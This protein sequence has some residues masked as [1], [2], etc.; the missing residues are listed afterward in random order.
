MF[1]KFTLNKAVMLA[2]AILLFGGSFVSAKDNKVDFIENKGQWEGHKIRYKA[3]IPGG[4]FYLTDKGFVYNFV[5]T[6]DWNAYSESLEH[7][8]KA[9]P[10]HF[11][12]Y[13]VNFVGANPTTDITST[14]FEKRS[15]YNN[16]FIG[17]D[18]SK[19][20][21]HVGLYGKVKLGN[22]YNGI[23]VYVYNNTGGENT[24]SLKYDFVVGAGVN[25]NQI[26]LSFDG[27]SPQIG[28]D[29]SLIIQTTVNKIVEQAP[30]CYQEINGQKVT[31]PSKYLL[32]NGTLTFAFPNGYNQNYPLVIDPNLVFATYSG[33][34]S[35][36]VYAYSTT[37]DDAGNLYAGGDVWDVGWPVTTGAFQTTFAG[38][39]HDIGINKYST[40]GTTLIYS[41]YYGGSGTEYPNAMRVNAQ[42]ELVLAGSTV[43]SDLPMGSNA[44][45]SSNGGGTDYFIAHF[46]QD[47]SS[48]I[49]ATY[50]GGSG[51]PSA[52]SIDANPSVMTG[53]A[54][55]HGQISPIDF[56]F[57]ANG[58]IWVVGNANSSTFPTTSNAQQAT[59]AGG[60]DGILAELSSDCSQLIYSSFLGGTGTDLAT[61]ILINHT[62]D[63]VVCGTTS[64]TNFPTTSGSYHS[65]AP[66]GSY[67][68]FVSII[69]PSNG[70]ISHSTYVG[71][72]KTDEAMFLQEDCA[73]NIYVLGST[74]GDYPISPGAWVT[75]SDGDVFVDKLNPDLSGSIISTR[76]G[77]PQSG[78]GAYYP[79][80]FLVDICGRTYLAGY[81]ES[82]GSANLPVT[83][84]AF[85]GPSTP[86]VNF[87]FCALEPSFSDVQYATF[88][89]VPGDHNHVGINRMDP[90][91]NV[92]Q[93]VCSNYPPNPFTAPNVWS[94]SKQT[95]GQDVLSFKFSFDI[96]TVNLSEVTGGGGNEAVPHAVRGCKS[97]Y[98]DFVRN[99]P[100]TIPLTIH[101][102]LSGT[103]NINS[104]YQV[105]SADSITIPAYDTIARLE[106]K[107]LI[108]PG[109]PTGPKNVHIDV[110]SPCGCDGGSNNI[111]ASGDIQIL[112]S[113]Y[114]DIPQPTQV[115]CA[116]S[117]VTVTAQIDTNLNFAWAPEN[118]IPD[119]R[120]LGLTI[121][122]VPVHPT[123]YTIT[124]T[125]PGAPATCPPHTLH[126][127][128]NVE[129]YPQV[130]M[131]AK[132]TIV[133]INPGDS[134][135]L[136][137]FAT[138]EGVNYSYQWS[139]AT[140]LRDAVSR[141][142][143][144]AGPVGD[145]H[146]TLTV[147]SPLAHCTGQNDMIIHVVP[148]FHFSSVTPADTI[149]NYG[150]AVKLNAEGNAVAWVWLP[151]SYLD[152]ANLQ[153]PT[154]KPEQS[155]QYQVVGL[156]EYGCRDT[157]KVNIQVKY[158][159][160]FFIPSAFSPN[161]DGNN[162]I[163]KIENLR[164]EKL[165]TF[166]V[167]NRLGQLVFST[168]NKING[169]DGTF[170]G[171][172]APADT[173]FYLIEVVL[174]DGEHQTFKGNIT[175]IR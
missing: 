9:Q 1:C 122:P 171:K 170:N 129:Q 51:T 20:A 26:K 44:Y 145:Y 33:A 127:F 149:V 130:T 93:S 96:A 161:G 173:Y 166:K 158:V 136:N 21:G 75:S 77:T 11:H 52:I 10:I 126:Y 81:N 65:T 150:D 100:D 147:S 58:N 4:A 87:W 116:N 45:Q 113:L 172:A 84:N 97:A 167:F 92:Y 125:Q 67:D 42:D 22:I 163:F 135:Q 94:P 61:G 78:Y 160:N 153:S 112:D 164:F 66:G 3:D 134:V 108:V 17:K 69:D 13:K 86:P 28:A 90:Q 175:L 98:F 50:L 133:C 115:V 155:I 114:V 64:S 124:V 83:S 104:D 41:T 30:Y 76:L 102:Q 57:D 143:M 79:T 19:W 156:D 23:D 123:D 121:H 80:S 103:A 25:V 72:D 62:G 71:T 24:S 165:L 14:G 146:Y 59:I 141:V 63:I 137:A 36:N 117:P 101:Y 16:Y 152:D 162:D 106:V 140:N 118:L 27:V 91:G 120:P 53:L 109:M 107:P 110:F 159:P 5:N 144:F 37:Y 40:D 142:N 55:G 47:G 111:I 15:Y 34:T 12:A 7:H 174:P 8:T 132:D 56:D 154:S 38:G 49:G 119:A 35:S 88:F 18:S 43:S 82:G 99:S 151:V 74:S 32:H 68:G 89:G 138:P 29:G 139:P 31:V 2:L 169:W 131:P 6:T 54:S 148:P 128:V 168:K 85:Q 105:I 46:S 70:S 39:G 73:G 48:L 95:S 157:G 60:T